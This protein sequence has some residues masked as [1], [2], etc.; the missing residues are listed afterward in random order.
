MCQ[1]S[2]MSCGHGNIH[3]IGIQ[4][5]FCIA[6]RS[7][8]HAVIFL[9]YK[10]GRNSSNFCLIC[11]CMYMVI[12][13]TYIYMQNWKIQSFCAD[14][15]CIFWLFG[16]YPKEYFSDAPL[17]CKHCSS[18]RYIYPVMFVLFPFFFLFFFQE[19]SSCICKGLL[20]KLIS[21]RI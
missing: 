7:F 11:F 12:I 10:D 15:T 5:I 2:M 3:K 17:L 14:M 19:Y 4:A 18:L 1:H 20:I 6:A 21:S 8:V 9:F 16:E 13:Y